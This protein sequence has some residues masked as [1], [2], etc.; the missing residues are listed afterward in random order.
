[1]SFKSSWWVDLLVNW[2]TTQPSNWADSCLL[3]HSLTD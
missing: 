3:A 2:P 1:M